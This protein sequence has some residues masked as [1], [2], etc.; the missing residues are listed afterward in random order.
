MERL[1]HW[2]GKKYVITGGMGYGK[3]RLITD[4]LA[5]YENTMLEPEQIEEMRKTLKYLISSENEVFNMLCQFDDYL[6]SIQKERII[7][8]RTN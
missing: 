7:D 5:A 4:K 1:T 6:K 2:N 8:A 3:T